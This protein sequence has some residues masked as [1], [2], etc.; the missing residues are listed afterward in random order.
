[1]T[2]RDGVHW[3]RT[4]NDAFIS[5]GL[6]FHEWTQRCFI[7]LGGI[8]SRGDYFYF[9]VSKNYMWEDAGIYVYSVPKY[10]FISLYADEAGGQVLTK[11]L[12]CTSDELYLNYVTSAYGYVKVTVIN[13]KG[14]D[15]YIS[16]EIFGNELSYKLHIEGLKGTK[17]RLKIE[18]SAAYL[19]AMGSCM[20]SQVNS[21]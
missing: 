4:L 13:E 8:V 20:N 16:D 10:R 17:G 19:Y 1:M 12:F 3:T 5:G 2:S 18:L 15:F 21:R 9:Y 7:P 14:E 6:Y 11:E